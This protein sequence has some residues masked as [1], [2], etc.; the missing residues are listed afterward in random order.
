MTI[1]KRTISDVSA[2]SDDYT[3]YFH[4]ELEMMDAF[5]DK[6]RGFDLITGNPPWDKVRAMTDGIFYKS[7]S[8]L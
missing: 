5:T 8:R 3:S 7:R 6:R 1:I 2:K 4:W